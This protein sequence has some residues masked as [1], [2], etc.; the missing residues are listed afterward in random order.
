MKLIK[1][2]DG[3]KI[4]IS[5][6]EW[7]N[8]GKITGWTKKSNVAVPVKKPVKS[9][10]KNPDQSP[11]KNPEKPNKLDPFHPPKITPAP[12]KAKKKIID[13]KEKTSFS[14]ELS[15]FIKLSQTNEEGMHRSISNFWKNIPQDHPFYKHPILSEYGNDLSQEGYNYIVEKMK[16]G[17]ETV[18]S[19]MGEAIG[20]VQQL[21]QLIFKFEATHE[22]ELINAA[23]D[24][25]SQIWGI[26]KSMLDAKISQSPEQGGNDRQETPD[27]LPMTPKLKKEIEKRIIMNTLTQGS[28]VHAMYSV[29]H[30]ITETINKISPELLKLYTRLS[31]LTTHHYYIIDIAA[32]VQMLKK[33]I[34]QSAIGWEHIETGNSEGQSQETKIVASGICFPVL[35]QELFK[36]VMELISHHSETNLSEQEVYTI[37][38]YADRLEDEP[39]ILTIGPALW[40]KFLKSIPDDANLSEIIMRINLE[41][42]EKVNNIIKSVIQNP[43]MAKNYFNSL[44]QPVE[45]EMWQDTEPEDEDE[46]QFPDKDNNEEDDDEDELLRNLLK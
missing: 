39:W 31:G 19:N 16:K 44:K 40:R 33:Q 1:T 30:L 28:A 3:K 45:K 41:S 15:S 35:C 12:S 22:E 6:K 13:N 26:D 4:K 43:D 29:H 24:I 11:S 34:G 9:P 42:P 8:I 25:T 32:I 38:H 27:L 2:A 20:E 46:W 23:K 18:P 21:M 37:Y 17:K 5:K 14:N 10:S 7:E 36:G